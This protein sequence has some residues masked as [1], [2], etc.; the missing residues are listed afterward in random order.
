MKKIR[1]NSLAFLFFF[2]PALVLA[3]DFSISVRVLGAEASK[4]QIIVSIFDSKGSFLKEPLINVTKSVNGLGEVSFTTKPIQAGTYAISAIYDKDSNGKLNTGL[5]GIPTE[6]VGFTNNAKG[7]M[8]PPSFK[9]A[10][11]NHD[12]KSEIIIHLTKAKE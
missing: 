5:L 1:F 3:E 12:K 2:F 7:L 11:F 9:K 6:K 4:G 10:S 8:G